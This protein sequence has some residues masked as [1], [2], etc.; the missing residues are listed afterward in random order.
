MNKNQLR[1]A[2][3]LPAIIFVLVPT[4]CILVGWLVGISFGH[5]NPEFWHDGYFRP[6]PSQAVVL[7][8]IAG[9]LWGL[10]FGSFLSFGGFGLIISW[11][12]RKKYSDMAPGDMLL[13]VLGWM[14]APIVICLLTTFFLLLF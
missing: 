1:L 8:G 4:I 5:Y 14:F 12:W 2:K 11:A 9:G 6:S 13:L 3:S 7:G 10:I